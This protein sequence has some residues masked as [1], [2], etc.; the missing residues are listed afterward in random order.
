MF[1]LKRM[2]RLDLLLLLLTASLVLAPG[3][4]PAVTAGLAI[5]DLAFGRRFGLIRALRLPFR[6]PDSLLGKH[7]LLRESAIQLVVGEL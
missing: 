5:T 2:E 3:G 4:L 7:C 6:L 1:A